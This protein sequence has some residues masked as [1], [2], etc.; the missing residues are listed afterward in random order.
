MFNF[1]YLNLAAK[2]GNTNHSFIQETYDFQEKERT[3][4]SERYGV[5][6][7]VDGTSGNFIYEIKPVDQ[8]KIKDAYDKVHYD[9]AV[10][11][12]W[13][14]N[15]EYKYYIDTITLIYY[16]RDNFRKDPIAFDF[17]YSA[18]RATELLT[19]ATYL[20]ECLNN[21][22]VPA[23]KTT[24]LKLCSYCPYIDI[25]KNEKIDAPEVVQKIIPNIVEEK[26]RKDAVF[27]F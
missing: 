26:K 15:N 27:L 5:K 8:T 13:I 25:C 22:K 18:A 16:I 14:L 2:I 19:N 11:G 1:V 4:I 7:R 24:D 3:V 6:G 21:N 20:H 12:A 10:I 17:P 23:F 9:Q